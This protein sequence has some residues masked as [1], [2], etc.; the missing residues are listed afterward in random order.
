MS[1][2]KKTAERIR[3]EKFMINVLGSESKNS[4]KSKGSQVNYIR[5]ICI[6]SNFPTLVS[7]VTFVWILRFFS[8][9]TS[10]TKDAYYEIFK[11]IFPAVFYWNLKHAFVQAFAPDQPEMT[12]NLSEYT[13]ETWSYTL[14]IVEA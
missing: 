12:L 11:K 8:I 4:Q 3:F 1:F 7:L 10:I 9:L 14:S 2:D 6:F 13:F 5:Q